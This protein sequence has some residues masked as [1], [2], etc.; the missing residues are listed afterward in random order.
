MT[1]ISGVTPCSAQKSSISWVSGMPPMFDPV[2]LRRIS[3]S[4]NAGTGIGC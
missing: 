2:R 3:A 4:A 1:S